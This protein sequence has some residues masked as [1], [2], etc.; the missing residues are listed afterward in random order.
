MAVATSLLHGYHPVMEALRAGRR[1]IH[2][3]Y[4]A[5]GKGIV[6]REE[7]AVAAGQAGARVQWVTPQQLTSQVGHRRH[8][9]VCAEVSAYPFS[10]LEEMLA[11]C[12]DAQ[13][14][15][16]LLLL[17][18]IVDPQNFG[19]IVRSAHCAGMHGVI[20]PKDHSAPPSAAVSKAS[21]G[22]LEHIRL[23]EV[24][25]LV[26][27][28]GELKAKGLWIAGADRWGAQSIYAT[29][30]KGPLAIVIGGEEK[31]LRP[32]VKKNCDFCIS[33]PQVGP[34]GSLNASAAAAV[35]IYEAFRQR[36]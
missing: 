25:N 13:C 9:D 32:L 35:I 30:L 7:I 17:D 1:R 5:Q 4:L 36:M 24:T 10:S 11:A 3:V 16:W 29:D 28:I 27:T 15:P 6:R 23:A 33:I 26:A 8:Q 12:A 22:A 19:A 31:G 21:A 34:V 2:T 20:V 14:L 18:Q